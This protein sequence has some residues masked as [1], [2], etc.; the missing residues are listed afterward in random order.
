MAKIYILN[1]FSRSVSFLQNLEII[2]PNERDGIPV[3]AFY[4]PSMCKGVNDDAPAFFNCSVSSPTS[5]IATNEPLVARLFT[6]PI[7]G[8]LSLNNTT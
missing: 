3:I 6:Y 4:S 2:L 5:C 8:E 1:K 7:V